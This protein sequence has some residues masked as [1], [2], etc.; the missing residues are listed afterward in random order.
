VTFIDAFSRYIV[1]HR[2][3]IDLHGAAVATELEAALSKA[4]KV[5]PRIVHEHGSD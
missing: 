4:G 5:R 1:H 2:L 3:L